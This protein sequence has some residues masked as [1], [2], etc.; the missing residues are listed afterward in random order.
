[1]RLLIYLL[2][3]SLGAVPASAQQ[4]IT[5]MIAKARER[6]DAPTEPFRIIGNVH[7]VGTLG[8]AS[9]LITGPDGH[10][11]VDTVMPGAANTAQITRNIEKLGFKV[12]DVKVMVN[13]H[14]HLDHTGNFADLKAAT[15]AQMI[16]GAKDKPLLETG[17]YP[18]REDVEALKFPPVKV[19]RT[20][21]DGDIVSVGSIKLVAHA[22]PGHSPGC[23]T[24]TTDV[25]DGGESHGV[26]FFCS[27]TVALNQ[28][29]GQPTHPGIVEDYLRTFA[30]AGAIK[31]DVLLAPHPEMYHMEAKRA[32]MASGGPN[33]F[34]KSGEFQAYL[35]RLKADFDGGL[36]KQEAAKQ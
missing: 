24:W 15:S 18:G 7:Y 16:S 21:A 14:A 17:T 36:A 9:Y 11:L 22:T 27:A 28:L 34:V 6:W 35:A 23:T 19:D 12:A 26:I 2:A 25:T 32:A 31:G 3:L 10:I 1:M 4:A 5:D 8:L 33:P 30:T 29:V 13:T 20:V